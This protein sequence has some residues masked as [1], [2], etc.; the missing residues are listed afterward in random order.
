MSKGLS[1]KEKKQ[2]RE[3]LKKFFIEGTDENKKFKELLTITEEVTHYGRYRFS[4]LPLE[5]KNNFIEFFKENVT[6]PIQLKNFSVSI[7][8]LCISA[9]YDNL[10][11]GII[12][13]KEYY[14]ESKKVNARITLSNASLIEKNK[15]DYIVIERYGKKVLLKYLAGDK[16]VLNKNSFLNKKLIGDNPTEE[17]VSLLFKLNEDFKKGRK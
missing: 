8:S 12:V 16:E 17:S 1:E 5:N 11:Y 15:T 14:N 3:E 7:H 9:I 13:E 4:S 10:E 2:L 6:I